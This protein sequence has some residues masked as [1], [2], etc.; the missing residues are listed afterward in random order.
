MIGGGGRLVLGGIQR[1]E[2]N[3][4]RSLAVQGPG[5]IVGGRSRRRRRFDKHSAIMHLGGVGHG[6][7]RRRQSGIILLLLQRHV[8]VSLGCWTCKLGM[9]PMETAPLGEQLL[10]NLLDRLGL[11]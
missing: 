8:L 10:G 4:H 3:V 5:D 6:M 9:I 1:L 2:S 7:K 11:G